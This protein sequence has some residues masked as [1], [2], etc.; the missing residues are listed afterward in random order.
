MNKK[1]IKYGL[2]LDA[3]KSVFAEMGYH[4]ASVSR[5]AKKAGIGDGT[6]YLYF[7]NKE[8]VL[9]KLFH[10]TIYN[11]FSPNVESL[12]EGIED[13]RVKLYELVRNHLHYFGNDYAL[14]KVI[15]I[16]AR[17]S[18]SE[19]REAMK[20]GI[21]RYFLLIESI[22]EDGQKKDVYRKDISKKTA[23]QVIFGSLDEVVT[24]W[25]LSSKSYLL[26]SKVDEVYRILLTAIYNFSF[27]ENL[28]W[29][30]QPKQFSET[31][32]EDIK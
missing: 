1:E 2:I 4:K 26:S 24:C 20:A 16:E 5:I 31:Q 23:R 6:V 18:S 30:L 19:I 15:Q 7:S 17:Q 3:A 8:D 12:M 9:K 27:I 29:T 10:N 22:I 21:K 32:V 28:P 13:P 14:S 11:E 25:V